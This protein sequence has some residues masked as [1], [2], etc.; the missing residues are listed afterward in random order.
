M[1]RRGPTKPKRSR[2][3][4]RSRSRVRR[5]KG[6]EDGWNHSGVLDEIAHGFEGFVAAEEARGTP[7]EEAL[8]GVRRSLELMGQHWPHLCD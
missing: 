1:V 5:I 3:S 6:C 8:A 2:G 7:T 4:L